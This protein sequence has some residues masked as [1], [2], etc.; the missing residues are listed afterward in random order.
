MTKKL[1]IITTRILNSKDGGFLNSNN[2]KHA[3]WD[4]SSP[5]LDFYMSDADVV[6]WIYSVFTDMEDLFSKELKNE[7][8]MRMN[9][10]SDPLE[11]IEE[12]MEEVNNFV[13]EQREEIIPKFRKDLY[14]FVRDQLHQTVENVKQTCYFAIACDDK[15]VIALPHLASATNQSAADNKK[16]INTLIDSFAD[17][18]EEVFLVL[19]DKDLYGYSGITFKLLKQNVV[20]KFCNRTNVNILVFQHGGN[21][22]SECLCMN[23]PTEAIVKLEKIFEEEKRKQHDVEIIKHW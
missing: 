19:H 14:V 2:C 23:D 8:R 10:S 4:A 1:F 20:E 3:E 7:L 16:W 15:E 18:S 12:F 5:M 6:T 9:I 17:K 11:N 21:Q 22:L 13:Q